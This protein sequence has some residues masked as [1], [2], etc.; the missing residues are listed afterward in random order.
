MTMNTIRTDTGGEIVQQFVC[1]HIRVTV[2][3]AIVKD[4]NN[5]IKD[6]TTVFVDTGLK[7]I[8]DFNIDE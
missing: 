2:H 8:V 6:Q 5:V 7:N 4:F 3:P 1:L